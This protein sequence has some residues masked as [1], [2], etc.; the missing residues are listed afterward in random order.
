M[1]KCQNVSIISINAH[2]NINT[3]ALYISFKPS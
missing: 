3:S 1:S 2:V